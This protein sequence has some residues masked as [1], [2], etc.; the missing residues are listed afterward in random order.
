MR[1]DRRCLLPV[2]MLLAARSGAQSL[3]PAERAAIDSGRAVVV[4]EKVPGSSWPR[5]TVYRFIAGSA[6]EAAAVFVDY[7]R[8]VAFLPN[9]R[10]S[11]ISRV[12]DSAT[13]EVDYVLNVPIVADESYTVRNRLTS[14][15]ADSGAEGR[16]YRVTWTLVRASS[17]KAADGE[18]LFTPHRDGTLLTYR[19]LVV[20][21]SRLASLGFIR[22]R[23][24]REV[25]ATARAIAEEVAKERAGDRELLGLQLRAL[26]SM[27][28][29]P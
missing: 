29:P 9:V 16:S 21:G 13:V 11:K 28:N 17:T 8:H 20:P 27:I 15:V 12:L 23:A 2:L 3:G 26:R 22:G 7:D 6:E 4:A 14:F 5:V 19:N 25:E 18:A 10:R 1:T 24:Q